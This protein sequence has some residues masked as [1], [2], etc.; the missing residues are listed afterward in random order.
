MHD[1]GNN[2]IKFGDCQLFLL[3]NNI[4]MGQIRE[5]IHIWVIFGILFQKYDSHQIKSWL[6]IEFD[7]I[8]FFKF[9]KTFVYCIDGNQ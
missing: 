4:S 7:P 3:E 1:I 8:I 2:T 6:T 5:N 9:S